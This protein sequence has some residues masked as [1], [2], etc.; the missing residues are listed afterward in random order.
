MGKKKPMNFFIRKYSQFFNLKDKN[1]NLRTKVTQDKKEP[2][3]LKL[4]NRK[5][6]ARLEESMNAACIQSEEIKKEIR[7]L[8]KKL[9]GAYDF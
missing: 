3:W 9:N 1:T 5:L 7:P 4:K 2:N 6:Y 8:N